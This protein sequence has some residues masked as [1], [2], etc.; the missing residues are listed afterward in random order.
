MKKLFLFAAIAVMGITTMKA[1][2]TFK[3][4]GN[5]ALPVGEAADFSSVGIGADVYYMFGAEDAF[6]NF[7]PTVGFRNYFG[8][9]ETVTIGNISVTSEFDD[10]Q[11]LPIAG[12]ARIKLIGILEA[13]ADVGYAIGISDDLDGGFY[14]RPL[15]GLD[16]LDFLDIT[17]SNENIFMDNLTWSSINLGVLF[18]F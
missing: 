5:F 3:I 14:V 2:G 4:G 18:S 8:K 6:L 17:L 1:Q 12:A 13:G 16:I 7:G 11:F 10:F 15:V 9:E